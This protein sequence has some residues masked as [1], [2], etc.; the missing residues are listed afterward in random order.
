MPT[1]SPLG[2]LFNSCRL[3]HLYLAPSYAQLYVTSDAIFLLFSKHKRRNNCIYSWRSI[4]FFDVH[5]ILLYTMPVTVKLIRTYWCV[6]HGGAARVSIYQC[7]HL[8]LKP[9]CCSSVY[10]QRN[11]GKRIV[12]VFYSHVGVLPSSVRLGL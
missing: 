9:Q 10:G 8:G 7:W 4:R 3:I 12:L 2:S 11:S 5:N 6:K 1:A